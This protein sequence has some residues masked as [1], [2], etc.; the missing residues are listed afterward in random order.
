MDVWWFP[1]V[2][3]VK[4]GNHPIETTI[5]KWL[6]GV[7]GVYIYNILHILLK[8]NLFQK[9]P[10]TMSKIGYRKDYNSSH[11]DQIKLSGLQVSHSIHGTEGIFTYILHLV[12][13]CGK[14]RHTIHGWYG[15]S[16]LISFAPR[17]AICFFAP[18]YRIGPSSTCVRRPP[19]PPSTCD[20]SL[21]CRG[22]SNARRSP[23]RRCRCRGRTWCPSQCAPKGTTKNH[24][25]FHAAT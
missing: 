21:G 15:Y 10:W 17:F 14:C 13:F 8:M 25:F 5:Y 19:F 22:G 4:I 12:D 23:C 6:F 7:P 1:T 18:L 24:A 9:R 3:Y 20:S 2:S 16:H 11:L